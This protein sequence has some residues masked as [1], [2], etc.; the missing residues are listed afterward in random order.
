L[1]HIDYADHFVRAVDTGTTPER[2][3]RAMFGDTPDAVERFIWRGLL[4]MR[5]M[6]QASSETVA[7]WRI[8]TRNEDWIRLE[9]ASW[10]LSAN[11]VVLAAHESVALATFLRYNHWLARLVWPPLSV[12]HRGLVPVVLRKA[13]KRTSSAQSATPGRDR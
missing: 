3:A 6:E 10:F 5:L 2:W 11:L 13:A 4:G 7:G 1:S 9:A 12:L 8:E